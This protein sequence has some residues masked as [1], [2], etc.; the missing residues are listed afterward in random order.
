MGMDGRTLVWDSYT[1]PSVLRRQALNNQFQS[2]FQFLLEHKVLAAN[3]WTGWTEI[4]CVDY[5]ADVPGM[6]PI[7]TSG[8][9]ICLHSMESAMR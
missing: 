2:Q 9:P 8:R 3:F 6:T 1:A 7:F 5:N 4:D